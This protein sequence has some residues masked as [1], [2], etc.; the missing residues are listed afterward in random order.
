[1]ASLRKTP[2]AD[3]GGG[4]NDYNAPDMIADSEMQNSSYNIRS[5][6]ETYYQRPGYFSFADRLTGNTD[7]IRCI[8]PYYRQ[9]DADDRL[10]MAYGTNLYLTDTSDPTPTWRVLTQSFIT[11]YTNINAVSYY[12]WLFVFNGVDKPLR[13]ANTTVTQPFTKPDSIST[14]ELFVPEFGDVYLNRL[15]VAGVPTAK[16]SVFISKASTTASQALI[17]DFS[18]T[19]ADALADANEI[20]FDNRITSIRQLSTACVIFTVSGAWYVSGTVEISNGV[21]FERQPIGGASGAVSH[22][23]TCSV[24]NDVYYLTPNKQIRSVRRD[25]SNNQQ[26]MITFQISKKIQRYLDEEIDDD[27]SSAFAF[28]DAKTREYNLYLRKKGDVMNTVR[29]IGNMD[30]IDQDGAPSWYI[31]ENVPFFSGCTFK[32][33][34]Y[35][36]SSVLGQVYLDGVGTADDDDTAIISRRVS[37]SYT[38]KDELLLKNFKGVD[39]YGELTQS[40]FLTVSVYVD[41]V[42]VDEQTISIADNLQNSQIGGIGT[43]QVGDFE[44]GDEGEDTTPNVVDRFPF[45]KRIPLRKRGK[46]LVIITTADGTTNNYRMNGYVYY[47]IATPNR[48]YSIS[49]RR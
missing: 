44:V 43:Q 45:Y 23:S 18:G 40:T 13:V 6:A 28:Y 24:N 1:M 16:N 39:L 14:A 31:D 17:C 27:L 34:R 21:S 15:F 2:I 37:K 48:Q 36:G 33:T 5:L 10:F 47:N 35:V 30:R 49:E 9:N 41:S 32:G 42:L 7:G 25:I 12:D 26:S 11:D 38:D 20:V 8:A 4:V 3:V 46:G 22:K 29:V 19:I